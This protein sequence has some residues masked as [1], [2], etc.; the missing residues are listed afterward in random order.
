[1]SSS[2][3]RERW[4]NKRT[5]QINKFAADNVL[6]LHYLNNGYQI[7]VEGLVDFYP[8]NGRYCILQTGERGDFD[9]FEDMRQI[10]LKALP[11]LPRVTVTNTNTGCVDEVATTLANHILSKPEARLSVWQKIRRAIRRGK[12]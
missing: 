3:A 11:P 4:R 12:I 9:T 8:T 6:R 10:M 5:E 7:R 2:A 1:M